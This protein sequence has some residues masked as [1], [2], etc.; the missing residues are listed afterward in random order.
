[1]TRTLFA[2]LTFLLLAVSLPTVAL[3]P[4]TRMI[5][6]AQFRAAPLVAKHPTCPVEILE[7]R[8]VNPRREFFWHD[9]EIVVRNRTSER[10]SD[11]TIG[12]YLQT[13]GV[14]KVIPF[15]LNGWRSPSLPDGAETE[16]QIGRAH[17]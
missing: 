15:H 7:I 13:G 12:L 2:Y 10:I 1:M 17:V 8:N 11:L 6:P 14:N 5:H 3:P 9:V 4:K 16:S